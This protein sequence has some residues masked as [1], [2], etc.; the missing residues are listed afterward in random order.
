MAVGNVLPTS[1][2][3]G[4]ERMPK[5]LAFMATVVLC[6][7]LGASSQGTAPQSP[8]VKST[9]IGVLIDVSAVDRNGQPV[10]DLTL[11][12]FELREN[13]VRQQIS[14]ARL[15]ETGV[16]PGLST[17]AAGSGTDASSVHRAKMET[18]RVFMLSAPG[19]PSQA[20]DPLP[21]RAEQ[22]PTHAG[23][24]EGTGGGAVSVTALVFDRL[25]A[26]ARPMA[27]RAALAYVATL[28]PANDYL[29]VFM[30]DTTLI[31]IEPFTTNVSRLRAAVDRM[32][33]TAPT[34]LRS[35]E[36]SQ[37]I[38][39][40]IPNT[41]PTAGAESSQGFK[42]VGDLIQRQHDESDPWRSSDR[43]L[44]EIETRMDSSY[45]ALLDESSGQASIAAL[46][47]TIRA[48]GRAEGRKTIF[49]FS[50]ALPVTARTKSLLDG[51]II[52]ANRA[53]VT[54]YT[55]DAAGLRVH[56]QE[57][58]VGREVNVAGAQGIG[59]LSRGNG[60]FTR[61]LERQEQVLSSPAAAVLGRLATDTGGFLLANT[62]DLAAG[63][64][65]M[66][67]DRTTYYL[68]AYQPTNATLDN[69]FRRV[70]VKVKRSHVS[71]RARPGYVA[72][73]LAP[74]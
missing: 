36:P 63:V 32:A 19:A 11:D 69:T 12:D 6:V 44:R 16:A 24:D 55:V 29:G 35:D 33:A 15:I 23:R 2:C 38:A 50:D 66:Q 59:D 42:G 68:L 3:S 62:N 65:R 40:T 9:A 39:G 49:Y 31:T 20:S 64:V 52:A 45:R 37:R 43:L 71:V 58:A 30:A 21:P 7:S 53:N 28:A 46:N 27:R 25:T 54:I 47:A 5:L 13:G 48:L 14:S 67:R 26:E 22:A 60:P 73:P 1:D 10:R 56:S 8:S 74:L 34:N 18:G 17:A 72:L 57:A 70:A 41:P 61:E 4:G 51:L